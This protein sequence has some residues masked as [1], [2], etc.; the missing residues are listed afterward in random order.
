MQGINLDEAS[1]FDFFDI[2]G[3]DIMKRAKVF[4]EYSINTKRLKHDYYKRVSSTGSAPI[5]N[6][7]DQYTGKA[8]ERSCCF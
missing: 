8:K 7:Y 2:D 4:N 3:C 6:I 5:M 1:L